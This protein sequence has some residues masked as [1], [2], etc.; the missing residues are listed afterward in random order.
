MEQGRYAARMVVYL[1]ILYLLFL[2][3][4][5][6]TQIYI[7]SCIYIYALIINMHHFTQRVCLLS[8]YLVRDQIR[9]LITPRKMC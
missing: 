4:N 5:V 2:Y 7:L 9:I 1:S 3:S 6:F 8:L